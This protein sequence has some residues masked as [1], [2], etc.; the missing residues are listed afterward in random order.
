MATIL[1]DTEIN[2]FKYL[3]KK[4]YYKT[5]IAEGIPYL[6]QLLRMFGIL[7][8]YHDNPA[9]AMRYL[10]FML[11]DPSGNYHDL[12]LSELREKFLSNAR[13]RPKKIKNSEVDSFIVRKLPFDGSNLSGTLRL[14]RSGEVVY[15]VKSFNGRLYLYRDGI[16]FYNIN[17]KAK[18]SWNSYPRKDKNSI[19]LSVDEGIFGEI[20][21]SF[22]PRTN[23]Q[24]LKDRQKEF[25]DKSRDLLP[26]RKKNLRIWSYD[27]DIQIHL[28]NKVKF[29]LLDVR[30]E[31]DVTNIDVAIF[32]I[33]RN[34]KLVKTKLTDYNQDPIAKDYLEKTVA[35]NFIK[36][37][38]DYLP[39]QKI[40][41][42]MDVRQIPEDGY[43]KFNFFH[44]PTN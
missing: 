1:S 31:G 10:Y 9:L 34:G 15:L 30:Q 6:K 5:S 44:Q 33:Y 25:A 32:G 19:L 8:S 37:I 41:Q 14:T 29:K 18:H 17:L 11:Y 38:M 16:W 35:G 22:A 28:E 43:I 39:L 7:P 24:I 27:P 42:Y 40:T 3:N 26:T 12:T 36:N 23:E 13:G 4:N 21:D 20:L 2:L